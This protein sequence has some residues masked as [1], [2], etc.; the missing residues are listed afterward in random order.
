MNVMNPVLKNGEI[1]DYEAAKVSLDD[2]DAL[3]G[4]GVYETLK[5]RK[6]IL[7]YPQFHEERLL[8]SARIIGIRHNLVPGD[9]T[10][11]LK[12]LIRAASDAA[13]NSN[14]KVVLLGHSG[15][16][17]DLYAFVTNPLYP[18]RKQLKHGASALVYEGERHFPAAKSLSM[19]MSTIAF[20][21]AQ[22]VGAYD[23]L[24]LTRDGRLTEGTRTNLFCFRPPKQGVAVVLTPLKTEVLEGITRRTVIECLGAAGYELR[25]QSLLLEDLIGAE[26]P[27]VFLTSTSTKILPLRELILPDGQRIPLEVPPLVREFQRLYDDYLESWAASQV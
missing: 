21:S 13:T 8:N 26:P 19:L 3:Y 1:V 16:P 18:D 4:Y 17:A 11:G 7:Y 20:R 12:K 6:G 9:L 23:A 14:L 10:A 24:L 15:R 2:I 22:A 25:E 27:A 5:V